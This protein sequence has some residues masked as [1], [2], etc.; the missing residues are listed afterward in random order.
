MNNR[1][2]ALTQPD[3]GQT[4][5]DGRG[6]GGLAAA[7]ASPL[8]RQNAIRAAPAE[9]RVAAGEAKEEIAKEPSQTR[10]GGRKT[11]RRRR[12]TTRR[13]THS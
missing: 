13:R 8:A 5:A 2:L 10:T 9:V 3:P 4:M 1:A 6:T 7:L 11:R 12:R